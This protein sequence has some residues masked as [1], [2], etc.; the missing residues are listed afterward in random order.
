[1]RTESGGRSSE[2]G[3]EYKFFSIVGVGRS[4]TSLLMSML[5]AHPRIALPPETHF[6]DQYVIG[7]AWKPT[8]ELIKDLLVDQRFNRI[9][10]DGEDLVNLLYRSGKDSRPARFYREMLSMYA[11]KNGV[12]VIGDKAPK[13]LEY[14]PVL[15]RILKGNLIIHVIRDPRDVYLS[16][17]KAAWSASRSDLSHLVAYRSQYGLARYFGKRMYG[18][19]YLEIKYE[20]LISQPE[21]E[22]MTICKHLELPYDSCMLDYEKSSEK[23]V[24]P[25]EMEWKKETLEPIKT[26]NINKWKND[27]K[28][29]K[30]ALIEIV[31]SKPFRDGFYEKSQ[32]SLTMKNVFLSIIYRP[33]A[34]LYTCW[35]MFKNWRALLAI[36][37]D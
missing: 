23:L 8:S 30:A 22:L 1:M 17:T 28:A 15:H 24:A 14:L 32:G 36:P 10:F 20:D 13:N 6:V 16:R 9:G 4:G 19:H 35:V 29:E 21:L 31:C 5:N 11:E 18:H 7:D 12:Q 37:R 34:F 25:D 33:I 26:D 2:I 27:L 3:M